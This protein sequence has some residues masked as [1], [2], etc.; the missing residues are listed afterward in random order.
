[1]DAQPRVY[2]LTWCNRLSQLYGATLTF[3]TL[4]IGFP[5]SPIYVVDS[6]SINAARPIF[7][8]RAR[9]VEAKFMQF[10]QHMELPVF[11]A[12]IVAQQK[13]GSAVF[14]DGDLCFWE[15]IEH[16][17]FDSLMAGRL[18]PKYAC[19][20]TGCITYPRIHSSLLWIPDV[21][22]LREA[23]KSIT[24][25][26]PHFQPFAQ[27]MWKAGEE[28]HFHDTGA[29]FYS[30]LGDQAYAFREA[31][32]NCYDHLFSGTFSDKVSAKL[33]SEFGEEYRRIHKAAQVDHRSI[34]GVW[35][36]Q[37]EYFQSRRLD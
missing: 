3:E 31:E 15:R 28:W 25:K 1:M 23:L 29:S 26:L 27:Y 18:I 22:K 9:A 30:V 13:T 14:L 17:G 36:I 37:E 24:D 32:L 35:R 8:G 10:P 5:N 33:D 2:L 34:R 21:Q 7:Q 12:H 19:D 16:W 6:A 11:F 4:R 20:F